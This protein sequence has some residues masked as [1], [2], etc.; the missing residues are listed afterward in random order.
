MSRKMDYKIKLSHKIV[1]ERDLFDELVQNV[2]IKLRIGTESIVF[3]I[4]YLDFYFHDV[5]DL[6]RE[7]KHIINDKASG[8]YSRYYLIENS[9]GFMKDVAERVVLDTNSMFRQTFP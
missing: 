4:G 3:S 6:I 7:K 8:L 9:T 1:E 2:Y 5:K